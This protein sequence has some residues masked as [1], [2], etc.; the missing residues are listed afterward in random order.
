M[1]VK[2]LVVNLQTLLSEYAKDKN[3]TRGIIKAM[4]PVL[5]NPAVKREI[6]MQMIDLIIDR[7]LS[8]KDKKGKDFKGYSDSYKKSLI[9]KI[10][11]GR[12]SKPDLKLTGNMQGAIDIVKISGDKIEIG[13]NDQTE[14]LKA[15]GHIKGANALPI[16][17]FWGLPTLDEQ[18]KIIESVVKDYNANVLETKI[19]YYEAANQLPIAMEVERPEVEED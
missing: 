2:P 14:E 10:Y 8:G 17:D 3:N 1:A 9:F 19:E 11:K 4:T 7:T 12:K 5:K 6:A 13:F 16:R 18:K 15:E